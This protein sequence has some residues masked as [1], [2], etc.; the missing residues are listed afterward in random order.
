[1]QH[2]AACCLQA[3]WPRASH[4]WRWLRATKE[5]WCHRV[6]AGSA[7]HAGEGEGRGAFNHRGLHVG[8]VRRSGTQGGLGTRGCTWHLE[9]KARSEGGGRKGRVIGRQGAGEE[10]SRGLSAALPAPCWGG[11]D[12]SRGQGIGIIRWDLGVLSESACSQ[13]PCQ[14]VLGSSRTSEGPHKLS[15]PQSR[16][17]KGQKLSHADKQ[18]PKGGREALRG[19]FLSAKTP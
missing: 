7:V 11:Q 19:P 6:R 2:K 3:Q 8:A 5:C 1:M 14:G 13:S 15:V 9:A 18:G 10:A 4:D 12:A 17:K 16:A